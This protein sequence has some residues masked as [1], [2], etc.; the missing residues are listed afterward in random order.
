MGQIKLMPKILIKVNEFRSQSQEIPTKLTEMESKGGWH[1]SYS[2]FTI[3]L[4]QLCEFKSEIPDYGV[5]SV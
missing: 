5:K 1:L 2:K 4:S 3:L